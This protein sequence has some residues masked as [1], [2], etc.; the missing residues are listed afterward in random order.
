MQMK[1]HS[2]LTL[3]FM[4]IPFPIFATADG[5]D[6]WKVQ[7]V[8]SNDVL[9]MRVEPNWQSN[10]VGEIPYNGT[11]LKTLECVGGLT[12]EEFT[13]LSE[14]EQKKIMKKRPRWCKVKFKDT[15]GWVS[16]KYLTEGQDPECYK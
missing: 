16:G 14:A 8:R 9:N 11:C 10:K 6:Y 3:V 1:K 12:F 15:T 7:K 2:I 5:P 4:I 13:T